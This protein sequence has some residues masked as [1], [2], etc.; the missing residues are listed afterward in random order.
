[1]FIFNEKLNKLL[2]N[3][4]KKSQLNE[5]LAPRT[6]GG[7]PSYS[8]FKNTNI[9][10]LESNSFVTTQILISLTN[11]NRYFPL[12]D[13]DQVAK[14]ANSFLDQY[15]EDAKKTSEPLGSMAYWPLLKTQDGRFIRSF[16]VEFPYNK[17]KVFNVPNDLDVSANYF[18]WKFS[19]DSHHDFLNSFQKTAGNY[20][21]LNRSSIYKNDYQWKRENS[22]AFLT[23]TDPDRINDQ[24]SR[25]F[26]GIND[27]DCVVNLNVLT[28][29]LT[30]QNNLGVLANQ[31]S[32]G[33]NSSCQLINETV[34]SGSE[35]KCM[36][37][38][39]RL[40]QFY[41]A[42]SKASV[43]QKKISCL[44]SSQ[45]MVKNNLITLANIKLNTINNLHYAEFSELLSSIKR[46]WPIKER[47]L[48][49]LQTIT[50]LENII[51]EGIVE[52]GDSAYLN[53]T[54]SLF[55]AHF[56]PLTIEWYSIEQST[57]LAIE[58]L[59]MP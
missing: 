5:N 19:D 56:N 36:V 18:M 7:W 44:Q 25:I 32:S 47:S 48:S 14:K 8:R 11:V 34:M 41:T 53:N 30:Y 50:K 35:N 12:N 39:D 42:Y 58:A 4:L 49:V 6:K 46:L 27:V 45:E 29:L 43:A 1:M 10:S 52:N 40:S 28:A 57:A 13:F 38:Y 31:T 37:W 23:W 26:K 3:Y 20:L 22:G 2:W 16:S 33:L 9:H 54:D 55:T 59:A 15:L 21:D 17:L 51:K 24:K